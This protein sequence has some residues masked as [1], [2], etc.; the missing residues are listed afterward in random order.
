MVSIFAAPLQR[1]LHEFQSRSFIAFLS[2]EGLQ[3]LTFV[4]DCPQQI[5]QLAVEL[6][7]HL[8]KMPSPMAKAPHGVHALPANVGREH[9]AEPIPSQSH[10]FVTEINSAL[11][12][13]VLNIAKA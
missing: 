12:K 11:E 5:V 1:T 6:H 8:I 2:D 7:V 10:G 4:I 13:Q 9:R 3:N